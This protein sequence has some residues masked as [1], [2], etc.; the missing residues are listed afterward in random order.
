M[1]MYKSKK[2]MK[3]KSLTLLLSFFFGFWGVHRFYLGQPIKGALFFITGGL[4]GI[5]WLR[6]VVKFAFISEESFNF[7]YNKLT[8]A[9]DVSIPYVADELNK[10]SLLVDQGV[11]TFEE[12]ERRK[13][14][15]LQF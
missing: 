3:S 10:L 5:G 12:F 6:D 13:S 11:I 7:H 14:K 4:F 1:K 2:D 8:N 15:I 9:P